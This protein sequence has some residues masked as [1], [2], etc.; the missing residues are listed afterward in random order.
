MT[1]EPPSTKPQEKLARL[2]PIKDTFAFKVDPTA[3]R[4]KNKSEV[5]GCL[6]IK[7]KKGTPVNV[8]KPGSANAAEGGPAKAP[9]GAAEKVE[10]SSAENIN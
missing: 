10:R 2:I 6:R 4:T 5:Q 8:A 7:N 3:Y 1:G 9:A